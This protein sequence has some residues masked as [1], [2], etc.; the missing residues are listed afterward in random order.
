MNEL[1][2]YS[3]RIAR[4]L[5]NSIQSSDIQSLLTKYSSNL[6]EYLVILYSKRFL[7]MSI[8]DCLE[9]DYALAFALLRDRFDV[10]YNIS[11][12]LNKGHYSILNRFFIESVDRLK[13]KESGMKSLTDELIWAPF[14]KI[15]TNNLELAAKKN[16][17][18]QKY[19]G[20][21]EVLFD[22]IQIKYPI[23]D[24]L[25]SNP[26]RSELM[27]IMAKYRPE[28]LNMIDEMLSAWKG[29]ES[30]LLSDLKV[31]FENESDAKTEKIDQKLKT[32]EE[33]KI[34]VEQL[35]KDKDDLETKAEQ[36]RKAQEEYQLQAKKEQIEK[37]ALTLIALQEKEANELKETQEQ[38]KQE[39]QALNS[40]QEQK[41]REV[42]F[43]ITEQERNEKEKPE[44]QEVNATATLQP[45]TINKKKK[46]IWLYGGVATLLLISLLLVVLKHLNVNIPFIN[47]NNVAVKV[48]TIETESKKVN[49]VENN[50]KEQINQL[51]EKED[52]AVKKMELIGSDNEPSAEVEKVTMAQESTE[53]N[54]VKNALLKSNTTQKSS[55]SPNKSLRYHLIAGSFSNEA[56]AENYF[57]ILQ[58]LGL[59]PVFLGLIDGFYKIAYKSF[60]NDREAKQK[61]LELGAEGRKSWIYYQR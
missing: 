24:D 6:D 42:L 25:S 54:S 46:S 50:E 47:E 43:A 52:E 14:D 48:K 60:N 27:A 2:P 16:D 8:D 28:K 31:K 33:Y 35:Q 13:F 3:R 30:E 12:S 26:F 55:T 7:G 41:D 57:Q 40:A 15:A 9:F 23:N 51:V 59:K 21:E 45:S 38:R 36:E 49:V 10:E 37:D 18:Y 17:L 19:K 61:L 4:A 39:E 53:E 32:Q 11:E 5:D 20:S 1:A 56:N 22:L 29:K 44:I 34:K 58:S